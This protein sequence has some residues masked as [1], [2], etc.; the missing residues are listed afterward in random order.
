MP[1]APSFYFDGFNTYANTT[2]SGLIDAANDA[3]G[4]LWR[5]HQI[6]GGPG[7]WPLR[8]INTGG[9]NGA[10]RLEIWSN[11]VRLRRYFEGTYTRV[12]FAFGYR[13]DAAAPETTLFALR[14]ANLSTQ[15][16]LG[17]SSGAVFMACGGTSLNLANALIEFQETPLQVNQWHYIECDVVVSNT[18]QPGQLKVRLN[19][20]EKV[21]TTVVDTQNSTTPGVKWYEFATMASITPFRDH[22]YSTFYIHSPDV[23]GIPGFIGDAYMLAVKAGAPGTHQDGVPSAGTD[24]VDMI[25]DIP[26]VRT[27]YNTLGAGDSE[28]YVPETLPSFVGDI[29]A[30]QPII[31]RRKPEAGTLTDRTRL[32]SGAADEQGR[33]LPILSSWSYNESAWPL[34][35]DG[36]V[37]WTKPAVQALEFGQAVQP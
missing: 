12:V 2:G 28:T 16:Q 26:V 5:W 17:V 23:S 6:T 25:D 15:F 30:V 9:R 19:G 24:H 11:N 29:V 35:P 33:L 18:C 32:I 21:N 7:G 13:V 8:V 1:A 37:P 34:N 4:I 20:V 22:W 10:G 31:T 36:N 14:D 3:T 27:T